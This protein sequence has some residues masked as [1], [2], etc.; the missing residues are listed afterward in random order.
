M[1]N[2]NNNKKALAIMLGTLFFL[3][4]LAVVLLS[5]IIVSITGE[6]DPPITG[7]SEQTTGIP[8]RSDISSQLPPVTTENPI[9]SSTQPSVT[10]GNPPETGANTGTPT[11]PF[12]TDPTPG[13]TTTPATSTS[14]TPVTEAPNIPIEKVETITNADGS[15]TKRGAFRDNGTPKVHLIVSWEAHYPEKNAKTVELT[16]SVYLESYSIGVA[17]RDNGTLVIG[18]DT[19]VFRTNNI[20]ISDNSIHRTLLTQKTVSYTKSSGSAVLELDI[21]AAWN[22]KGTYSGIAVDWITVSGTIEI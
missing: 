5:V 22:F 2:N 13:T 7:V 18:E 20:H 8:D 17:A 19:T 11:G 4:V 14:R 15:V 9:S 1:E 10:T 6:S 12:K 3:L 21:D 16:V